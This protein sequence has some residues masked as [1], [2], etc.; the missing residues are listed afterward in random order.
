VA[1]YVVRTVDG[2]GELVGVLRDVDSGWICHFEGPEDLLTALSGGHS[3]D[4]GPGRED[5]AD[6]GLGQGYLIACPIRHERA[7]TPAQLRI[8]YLV[9]TQVQVA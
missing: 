8:T 7:L 5:P 3:P 1:T 4:P 9:A 2:A 6:D